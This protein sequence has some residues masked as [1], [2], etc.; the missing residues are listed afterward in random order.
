MYRKD[1]TIENVVITAALIYITFSAVARDQSNLKLNKKIESDNV[2]MMKNEIRWSV[3]SLLFFFG[4][5]MYI[6][7]L[8]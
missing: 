6:L 3:Y 2:S 8:V 4:E 7:I 5:T 1:N